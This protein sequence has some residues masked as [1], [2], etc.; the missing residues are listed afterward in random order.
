MRD[1]FSPYLLVMYVRV[2]ACIRLQSCMQK[3]LAVNIRCERER[4][5]QGS[6]SLALPKVSGPCTMY[7]SMYLCMSHR[8]IGLSD[9]V[10]H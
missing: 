10:T 4:D 1:A 5:R 6:S 7:V 2:L 9:G 3:G 8:C